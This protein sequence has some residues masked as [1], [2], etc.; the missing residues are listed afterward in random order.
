[1]TDPALEVPETIQSATIQSSPSASHDVNPPTAASEKQPV[2]AAPA[3]EADS[4]PSDIVDPRRVIRPLPRRQALPPLPDLRFEQSYLASIKDA[5]TWG[6]VAWITV[7]DQ[8]QSPINPVIYPKS[9]ELRVANMVISFAGF[10]SAYSRNGVDTRAL[11]VAF[12]EP[13]RHA[14]R[15]DARQQ[16][17][18]VVVRGQQLE[19]TTCVVQEPAVS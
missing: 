10:S 14:Q 12:L 5:D 18:A 6:R 11:R 8:V 13:Q 3:S 1:M 16:D 2:V 15:T 9:I 7:R 17:P 19:S 4:I